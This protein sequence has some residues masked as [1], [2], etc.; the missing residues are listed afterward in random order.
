MPIIPKPGVS[1]DGGRVVTSAARA[2]NSS[3]GGLLGNVAGRLGVDLGQKDVG[4]T[5][6][7]LGT[8]GLSPAGRIGGPKAKA[9]PVSHWG[10]LNGHYIARLFCLNKDFVE[11]P[12]E[13]EVLAPITDANIEYALNWQSPFENSGPE[14]KAPALMAL[15]QTGQI[16]TIAE[17]LQRALPSDSAFG[18]MASDAAEKTKRWARELEGRT[19]I[20]KLNSRQVFSGMPPVK[21]TMTMHFRALDDA[22][23]QVE[24]PWRRLLEWALPQDLAKDGILAEIIGG[25]EGFI[26]SLFPS[27]AP[28]MVGMTYGRETYAPLVIESIGKPLDGPVTVQGY[29]AFKTVPITL[30]TLTALDRA[31][32]A[33]IYAGR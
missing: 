18:K 3:T 27:K 13:G 20:T 8:D 1:L 5:P 16:A 11:V 31:D 32:V 29:P 4:G 6:S 33:K 7:R 22:R 24:E 30:A 9:G 19:G 21:I 25:D 17:A 15:L 2:A 23:S 14:S 10:T 12:T 28:A 26:K